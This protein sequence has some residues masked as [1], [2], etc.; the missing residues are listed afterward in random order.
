MC[1]IGENEKTGKKYAA[2][3]LLFCGSAQTKPGGKLFVLSDKVSVR[4]L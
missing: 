3:H 1:F 2:E 4:N